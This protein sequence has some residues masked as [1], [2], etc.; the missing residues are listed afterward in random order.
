MS[1][2]KDTIG[3]RGSLLEC[4]LYVPP[5]LGGKIFFTTGAQRYEKPTSW[6]LPILKLLFSAP[7]RKNILFCRR[8]TEREPIVADVC[9]L[10]LH[11]ADQPVFLRAS[12]SQW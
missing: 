9:M 10:H 4:F 7:L 8:S 1:R 3:F 5:D 12:V 11:R 6:P 2:G